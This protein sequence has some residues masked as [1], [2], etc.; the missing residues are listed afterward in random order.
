M[1]PATHNGE[2]IDAIL[3]SMSLSPSFDSIARP[4]TSAGFAHKLKTKPLADLMAWLLN[5]S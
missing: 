2:H 5:K 3:S 1:R 4:G